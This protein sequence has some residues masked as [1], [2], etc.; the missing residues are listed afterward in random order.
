MPVRAARSRSTPRRRT[1]T[2]TRPVRVVAG[3]IPLLTGRLDWDLSRGRMEIPLGRQRAEADPDPGHGDRQHGRSRPLPDRG[4]AA[5][6]HGLPD[7][8]RRGS[9]RLRARAC[10]CRPSRATRCCARR[11]RAACR[12]NRCHLTATSIPIGM[13][14]VRALTLDFDPAGGS[15]TGTAKLK[16]PGP[17]PQVI[18]DAT[19]VV[20]DGLV[21]AREPGRRQLA[22]HLRLRRAAGAA[23]ARRRAPTRSG[24]AAS[25]RSARARRCPASASSSAS[26][27]TVDFTAGTPVGAA[28]ARAL[29][30]RP[31]DRHGLVHGVLDR[32]P[33]LRRRSRRIELRPDIGVS[34]AVKG[35]D[36]AELVRVSRAARGPGCSASHL[37]GD[38]L[39]SS[40]GA[41]RVRAG[42]AAELG[43]GRPGVP[44][45]LRIPVRDQAAST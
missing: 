33:G 6:R 9:A 10:A 7:A 44:R 31:G 15:W 1:I 37:Q 16:L 4:A 34:A 21:R 23:R 27:G 40:V 32:P 43:Q 45:R 8:S 3:T 19:V 38:G 20:R 42:E 36:P 28:A 22:G 29:A 12:S 26:S 17:P 13:L 24:S 5:D 35:V 2:S 41:G 30:G 11:T 39:F 25:W 18:A 14:E